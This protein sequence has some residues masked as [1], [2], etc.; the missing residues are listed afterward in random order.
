MSADRF[1]ELMPWYVNGTISDEDRAWVD[2]HMSANPDA[3][4]ELA[5]YQSL[6]TRMRDNAP[7][8]PATIGLARTMQLI[9]GDQPTFSERVTA[10][11]AGFGLRPTAAFAGLAVVAVQAGFIF[12]LLNEPKDDNIPQI[13]GHGATAVTDAPLLKLNFAPD[14]KEAD[15]RLLLISVHGDLVAGPGQLGDYYVRVPAG[16]ASA[17]LAALKTNPIVQGAAIEAGVPQRD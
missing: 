17:S 6:Q 15:I 5:F 1:N 3:K 9:R 14:A 2:A 7:A 12:T 8:V 4:A 13:R 11:F 16:T 10:F